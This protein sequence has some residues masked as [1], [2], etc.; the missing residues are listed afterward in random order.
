ME[1]L[2]P[3]RLRSRLRASEELPESCKMYCPL[4]PSMNWTSQKLL[5]EGLKSRAMLSR[6]SALIAAFEGRDQLSEPAPGAFVRRP[7]LVKFIQAVSPDQSGFL[8]RRE[9]V[10]VVLWP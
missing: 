4:G 7:S 8:V 10:I 2:W 5:E 9:S 1:S 3:G 6:H